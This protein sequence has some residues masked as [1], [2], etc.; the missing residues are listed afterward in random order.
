[1]E[2]GLRLDLKLNFS[3]PLNISD[4][5]KI[6]VVFSTLPSICPLYFPRRASIFTRLPATRSPRPF[7]MGRR[8]FYRNGQW[9]SGVYF[10]ARVR[11]HRNN[12]KER[13]MKNRKVVGQTSEPPRP[14]KPLRVTGRRASTLL[15]VRHIYVVARL[16]CSRIQSAAS[17]T[18]RTPFSDWP[19]PRV[20]RVIK[21]GKQ[22]IPKFSRRTRGGKNIGFMQSRSTPELD[23]G[24]GAGTYRFFF[25]VYDKRKKKTKEK[26]K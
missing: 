24:A 6:S 14:R 12:D 1:M 7:P 5:W 21:R 4:V 10:I 19:A 25:L 11:P 3:E 13:S 9:C 18:D 23:F 2:F 8:Y 20:R 26:K 17:T 22:E 15:F 16:N